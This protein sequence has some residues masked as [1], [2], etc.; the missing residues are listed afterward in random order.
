M[1][2]RTNVAVVGATG[3]VGSELL[4]LL[5]EAGHPAEHVTALASERSEGEEVAYGDESLE[6]E[7]LSAESLHGMKVAFLALPEAAA[8]EWGKAAQAEGAWVVDAC[9]AERVPLALPGLR[10]DLL[11]KDFPGRIVHTAPPVV[12][13]LARILWPLRDL[14]IEAVSITALIAA[15]AEG[16][17]GISELEKQIAS[18]LSARDF[19]PVRFPHRM[20]FNLIPQVGPLATD[21]H[22]ADEVRWAEA[23]TALWP[24]DPP[25]DWSFTGVRVPVF[26]GDALSIEIRLRTGATEERIRQAIREGAQLKLLD[27]PEEGI[28]PMPMLVANDPDVHVGRVRVGASGRRLSLFAVFDSARRAA[29]C[30]LDAADLLL[31]KG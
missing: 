20:G 15:A 9:A 14:G 1:D 18:L 3:L 13:A 5:A 17:P 16:R 12:D 4:A 2:P 28:Y 8:R 29:R 21:G 6:V 26:H 11:E 7:R 30:A 25:P 23:L 10:P 27:S 22:F 19:E 24:D 31:R